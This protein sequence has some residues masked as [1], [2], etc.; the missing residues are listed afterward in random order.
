MIGS[1][2]TVAYIDCDLFTIMSGLVLEKTG[3]FGVYSTGGKAVGKVTTT[4]NQPKQANAVKSSKE[5]S[6][7]AAASTPAGPTMDLEQQILSTLASAGEISDTWIF[8]ESLKQDHQA[9]VGAVKSL[10]VDS[11]VVDEPINSSFWELTAEGN[12]IASKGS[13]EYQVFQAVP[14]GGISVNALQSALGEVSKIGLGPCMKNKWL[15]KDGENIVRLVS[16]VQDET[17]AQLSAVASGVSTVSEED[18]KN[19]KRRKLPQLRN[20]RRRSCFSLLLIPIR[21]SGP[22][23]YSVDTTPSTRR[24][25]REYSAFATGRLLLMIFTAVMGG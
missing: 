25:S 19:L 24:I 15:K 18:L 6:T 11:Y 9:V 5:S 21:S 22:S 13:P 20:K 3:K 12:D 1:W 23:T 16:S 2:C 7:K 4:N 17:A 14:E 10:L 8:A